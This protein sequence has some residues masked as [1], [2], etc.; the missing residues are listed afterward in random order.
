MKH[1]TSD[2]RNRREHANQNGQYQKSTQKIRHLVHVAL[3]NAELAVHW[4]LRDEGLSR[5]TEPRGQFDPASEPN[6]GAD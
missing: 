2:R 6:T 3:L 5:V 4:T 1:I